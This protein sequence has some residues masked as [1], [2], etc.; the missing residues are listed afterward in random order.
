MAHVHLHVDESYPGELADRQDEIAKAVLSRVGFTVEEE[1]VDESPFAAIR[2]SE[3]LV[4]SLA[5]D[6]LGRM[7]EQ[8]KRI[9]EKKP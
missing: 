9:L 6:Q 2:E 3:D 4:E 5:L 8:I 7:V 1:I